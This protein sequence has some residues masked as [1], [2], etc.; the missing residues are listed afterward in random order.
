MI[1]L[2]APGLFPG[3]DFLRRRILYVKMPKKLK[4]RPDAHADY[5][6]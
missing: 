6:K 3:A 4:K 5:D 1:F 2:S